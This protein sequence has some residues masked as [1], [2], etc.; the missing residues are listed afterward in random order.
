MIA[1]MSSKFRR[2]A[3]GFSL[4]ELLVVVAIAAILVAIAVPSFVEQVRKSRR[5]EAKGLL[6]QIAVMQEQFRTE[7][8]RYAD[9]LTLLGL[10]AAGW[11]QSENGYYEVR[12]IPP[13]AGCLIANCF[14]LEV[15]PV[16]GSAQEADEWMYEL[17]SDG[18]KRR[19]DGAAGAWI[20]DWKK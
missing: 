3:R 19:R 2:R 16:A 10:P 6:S 18:R 15:R 9:D 1:S 11:N 8:N 17:W 7:Q 20:L 14:R 4:V 12:V 5:G 13:I